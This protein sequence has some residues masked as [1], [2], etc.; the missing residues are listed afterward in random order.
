MSAS[1]AER[2]H[3][4]ELGA[5]VEIAGRLLENVEQVVIGKT[6]VLRLV[7]AAFAARGHV[8]LEDVPGTAKTMLARALAASVVDAEARI[9][10]QASREERLAVATHVIDNTGTIEDLRRRVTVVV[11]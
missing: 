9:A 8:L 6:H 2:P 11:V 1:G 7:L 3:V 4:D 10:A 5:A